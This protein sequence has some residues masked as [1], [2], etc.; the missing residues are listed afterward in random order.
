MPFVLSLFLSTH[1]NRKYRHAIHKTLTLNEGK[2]GSSSIS[3]TA[4]QSLFDFIIQ[5]VD[6]DLYTL[7]VSF[8]LR[9]ALFFSLAFTFRIP[10][11]SSRFLAVQIE[12]Q[13]MTAV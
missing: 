10:R 2:E 4:C 8:N 13:T 5:S 7:E 6:F 1:F 9:K 3:T 11:F 12:F